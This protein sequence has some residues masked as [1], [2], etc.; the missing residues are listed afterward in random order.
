M[1]ALLQTRM[2]VILCLRTKEK[3]RQAKDDRGKDVIVSDGL[4]EIQEK[5]FIYEMTVSAMVAN[6]GVPTLTKCPDTLRPAFAGGRIG[7]E[8]GE[9]I[10]A[11]LGNQAPIDNEYEHL[12]RQMTDTAYQGTSA[13]RNAW[14]GL[15]T[16]QKR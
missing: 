3:M 2:H 15:T 5:N 7:V 8:T 12:K 1:Q 6:G 10:A 4:L 13:L 16:D 14:D 11:W 9:A